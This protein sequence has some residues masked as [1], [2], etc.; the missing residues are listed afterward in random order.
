MWVGKSKQN[1]DE[2]SFCEPHQCFAAGAV[3]LQQW[4]IYSIACIVAGCVRFF[5]QDCRVSHL[6]VLYSFICQG[7]AVEVK[8]ELLFE[9][10][11]ELDI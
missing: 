7:R 4:E 9:K 5:G 11:Q 1:A 2:S 3:L 10:R 8:E 6:S